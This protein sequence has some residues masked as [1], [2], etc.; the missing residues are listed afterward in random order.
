MFVFHSLHFFFAG[1]ESVLVLAPKFTGPMLML[2]ISV[3]DLF[4]S[5]DASAFSSFVGVKLTRSR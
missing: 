3:E 1:D 2:L 4:L 5:D